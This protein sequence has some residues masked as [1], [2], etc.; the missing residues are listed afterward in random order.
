M[1]TEIN[2]NQTTID[3]QQ[4]DIT[5]QGTDA[6]VNAANSALAGGGGVDGAIHRAAGADQLQAACRKIGGC[7]T[8]DAVITP[9][10]NLKAKHII[11][12][13]GPIYKPGDDAPRLLKGAYRRSLE[14]A[15]E[16]NVKSVALPAI[17]TGIF[18]YPMSEAAEIALTTAREFAEENDS[19]DLI[20]FVL[21]GPDAMQAFEEALENMNEE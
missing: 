5:Q 6:I 14:V 13:V 15:A 18:G 17:S 20:R 10:F 9:G 21:F 16:N 12:A 2:V 4:G 8:G 11:H 1:T 7:P 3:L 19:I